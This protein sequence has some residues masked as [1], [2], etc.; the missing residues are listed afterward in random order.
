MSANPN[1]NIEKCEMKSEV[2][3]GGGDR[4]K[5]NDQEY[6]FKCKHGDVA[7]KRCLANER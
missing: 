6:H 1:G 2:V 7:K 5:N 4:C 3:K